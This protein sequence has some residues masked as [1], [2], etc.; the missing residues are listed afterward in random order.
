MR[1][2]SDP[3]SQVEEPQRR[4]GPS[5]S[6]LTDCPKLDGIRQHQAEARNAKNPY[7]TELF[8]NLRERPG[9]MVKI[10]RLRM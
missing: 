4:R 8:G 7:G 2:G 1:N 10:K 5:N 3:E 9:E 6:R